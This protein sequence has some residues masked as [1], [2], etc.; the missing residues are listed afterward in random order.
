MHTCDQMVH[1]L[2]IM[3]SSA[4]VDIDLHS[5][6]HGFF[7]LPPR[8]REALTQ[9]FPVIKFDTKAKKKYRSKNSFCKLHEIIRTTEN[10]EKKTLTN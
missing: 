1:S 3:I 2:F 6:H 8:G 4:V 7:F 9:F 5:H 10:N